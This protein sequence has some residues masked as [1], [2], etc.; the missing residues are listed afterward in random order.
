MDCIITFDRGLGNHLIGFFQKVDETVKNNTDK[1]A[2]EIAIG[3]DSGE[4][5]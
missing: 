3:W 5:T 4:L 2:P 1:K